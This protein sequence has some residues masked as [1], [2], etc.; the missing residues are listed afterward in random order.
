M[1]F[2]HI[3]TTAKRKLKK[4]RHEFNRYALLIVI[5]LV[6][7]MV[8]FFCVR[9]ITGQQLNEN[10]RTAVERFQ[11]E[12]NGVLRELQMVSDAI[13]SDR[14][15]RE[16]TQA[17]A[18][19]D[20]F[21]VSES[22]REHL[23]A[24]RYVSEVFLV[25][26]GQERIISSKAVFSYDALEHILA[27]IV[28]NDPAPGLEEGWH[29]LNANYSSPYY[30]SV[31][32]DGE[33]FLL[34]TLNKT[35]FVRTLYNNDVALCGL[36]DG[37]FGISSS[38]S[39]YSV[40]DFQS[41]AAVSALL[42]ERVK[43]FYLEENG[44][45]YMVALSLKA[46][47][48][49]Q[50][51][52]VAV[53][54]A[55]FLLSIVFGLIYLHYASKKRYDEAASMLDGLPYG[56]SGD[57]PYEDILEAMRTSLEAYKKHYDDQLRFKKRSMV[58]SFVSDSQTMATPELLHQLGLEAEIPCYVGLIHFSGTPGVLVDVPTP[59]NI[60]VTCTVL[61][62]AL[63]KAAGEGMGI[64]VSHLDHNYIVILSVQQPE[65]TQGEIRQ[66]FEETVHAVESEYLCRLMALVSHPAKTPQDI[67]RAHKEAVSL[68][69]FVH[70]TQS[71]ASVLLCSD[72]EENTGA[73]LNGSFNTQLQFITTTLQMG[74]YDL[75]P[76]LVASVLEEQVSNLGAHYPLIQSRIAAVTNALIEAV[77]AG[78]MDAEL[79]NRYIQQ[80]QRADSI[81]SLNALTA[82]ICA[83]FTACEPIDT[84][85][86][87]VERA[88]AYIQ[89][90]LS[91]PDLS[92]P[93]VGEAVGLSVQHLLRLFRRRYNMTVV[94]Y[95]N[96]ARIEKAKQLLSTQ[97]MTVAKVVEAVGYSNNVTFSRNFKR[98]VGMSPS[99]YRDISK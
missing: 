54:G 90:N 60:D 56:V 33:T 94:E 46:Y 82:E 15:L 61:Y 7:G 8:L 28:G 79:K 2:S 69:E 22:L 80:L 12:V 29:V 36:Y 84:G 17:D 52:I 4:Y 6:L 68:Y 74:K 59:T 97:D 41:A 62:S 71:E 24:S 81:E 83:Q 47:R 37:E 34:V 10:G 21:W 32:P 9:S 67:G 1:A 99:D 43:C 73:L 72:M 78:R 16:Y 76:S 98:Y 75:A 92:V 26:P 88:I 18:P 95:I 14:S 48:A 25:S 53:F 91:R 55:Y 44:N 96:S 63:K 85:S 40:A 13:L 5:P 38:L 65:V 87:T 45:T 49:P 23:D 66:V 58:S 19:G 20:P 93:D 3:L 64:L 86:D 77:A 27:G 30:L 42:G 50:M 31:F 89:A 11:A 39:N 35:S 70:S 57:S 51:A